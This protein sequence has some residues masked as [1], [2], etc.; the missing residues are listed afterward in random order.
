MRRYVV[1]FCFVVASHEHLAGQ[2]DMGRKDCETQETS[3]VP[4]PSGSDHNPEK[5]LEETPPMRKLQ[6]K[7]LASNQ[8]ITPAL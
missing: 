4:E 6:M 5:P 7:W 1:T 8:K 2:E 3:R